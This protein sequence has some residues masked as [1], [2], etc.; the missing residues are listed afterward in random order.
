MNVILV[1][2]VAFGLGIVLSG[3]VFDQLGK[4]RKKND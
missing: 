1:A 4:L 2:I 3:F